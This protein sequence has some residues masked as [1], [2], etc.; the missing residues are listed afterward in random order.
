MV[1]GGSVVIPVS[2]GGNLSQYLASL[3]RV[4]ELN[5]SRML[6]AHGQPIEEPLNLLQS[7]LEHRQRREDQVVAALRDGLRRPDRIAS[8]LYE[9]LHRSLRGMA[10]ESVKAHLMKLRDEGRARSDGLEWELS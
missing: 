9:G 5:P 10:E 2:R 7:Y 8:R 4:K 3:R 1:Y 6:P